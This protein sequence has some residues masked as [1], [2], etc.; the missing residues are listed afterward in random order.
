[1]KALL[2]ATAMALVASGC[3]SRGEPS[4]PD[5]P[6]TESSAVPQPAVT[7]YRSPCYAG[8][9]VYSVSVTADGLVSYEGRAQ[10]RQRG[11]ATARIPGAQVSRLLAELEAAGYFA[12]ASRY[13]PSEPVCGR[14]VPDAPTIITAARSGNL[15][16]RIEH[17]HGC[18]AAPMALKV[19]ES[20]IDEV[21]GSE[22]WTGR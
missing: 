9:P 16:K 2:L 19:L 5:T 3:A 18:G 6:S 1:M 13:R 20:R 22:R 11:T 12:F 7:L 14:Y 17:D 4:P 10:V 15:M 8:C 21:L